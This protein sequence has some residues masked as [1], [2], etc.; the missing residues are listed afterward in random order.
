MMKTLAG[1]VKR[2]APSDRLLE[3]SLALARMM[4]AKRRPQHQLIGRLLTQ[5]AS[6]ADLELLQDREDTLSRTRCE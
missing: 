3:E 1:L 4:A 5:N 6:E 2:V